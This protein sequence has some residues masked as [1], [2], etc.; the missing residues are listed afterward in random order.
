MLLRTRSVGT[1]SSGKDFWEVVVTALEAL[2]T[3]FEKGQET[4]LISERF[5]LLATN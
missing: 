3:Q 5:Y 4:L 2:E 1:R